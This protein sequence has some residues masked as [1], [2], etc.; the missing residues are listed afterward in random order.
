M[1]RLLLDEN[2]SET[3]LRTISNTYP[4]SAHVRLALRAGATDEEVWRFARDQGFV[5]VTRD[6][7]FERLSA[8]R[9]APPTVVWLALHTPATLRSRRS[10]MPHAPASTGS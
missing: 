8:M 4:G 10:F 3:I 5:L 7:D 1:T 2:L 9:G 6:E